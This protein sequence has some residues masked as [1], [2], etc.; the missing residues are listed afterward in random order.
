L[1]TKTSFVAVS[2]LF[3]AESK[4]VVAVV[5]T[6]AGAVVAAVG[7]FWLV[8]FVVALFNVQGSC[9]GGVTMLSLVSSVAS[10]SSRWRDGTRVRR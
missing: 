6:L 9:R 8:A 2:E 7:V 10:R 1:D 4:L 3:V 5:A